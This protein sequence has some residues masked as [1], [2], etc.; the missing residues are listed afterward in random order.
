MEPGENVC[1][2]YPALNAFQDHALTCFD[3]AQLEIALK[4]NIDHIKNVAENSS[5]A[6]ERCRPLGMR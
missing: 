6:N 1:V 2:L 4:S 3:V 5:D